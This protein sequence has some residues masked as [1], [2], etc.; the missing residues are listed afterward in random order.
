MPQTIRDRIMTCIVG[1]FSAIVAGQDGYTRGWQ[2]V[3]QLPLTKGDM[4]AGGKGT[5]TI[6]I[7]DT[8]EKVASAIGVKNR[9]LTVAIEFY[10]HIYEG[11]DPRGTV[12]ILLG[13]IARSMDADPQVT[14]QGTGIRLAVNTTEVASEIDIESARDHVVG[15]VVI[16]QVAYRTRAD[17]PFLIR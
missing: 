11:A 13:E 4:R 14:E 8:S 1:R 12:G 5:Q 9:S 15:G 7:F 17:S 16:F 3:S 6:G 2:I 10:A